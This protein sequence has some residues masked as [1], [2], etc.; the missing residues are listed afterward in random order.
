M[1]AF[2]SGQWFSA[3]IWE[4]FWET[5]GR[6]GSQCRNGGKKLGRTGP[7]LGASQRA[8]RIHERVNATGIA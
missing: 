4:R 2:G 1:G 5:S 3:C 7:G 8:G 6:E